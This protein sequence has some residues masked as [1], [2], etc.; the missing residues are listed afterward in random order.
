MLTIGAKASILNNRARKDAQSKAQQ[1]AI[2]KAL[3]QLH[4]E[5]KRDITSAELHGRYLT[6]P[7]PDNYPHVG[8]RG[9]RYQLDF[10][11]EEEK[12]K[13]VII[14]RGSHGRIKYWRPL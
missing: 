13:G 9:M 14:S 1:K 6:M 5:L 10:L 3:V 11:V 4:H 8:E 2:M 12:V 7:L